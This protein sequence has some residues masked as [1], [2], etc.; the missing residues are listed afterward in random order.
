MVVGVIIDE[1]ILL[2]FGYDFKRILR[3]RKEMD[4]KHGCRIWKDLYF[5]EVLSAGRYF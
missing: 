3:K 2:G 1:N 5:W 4:G